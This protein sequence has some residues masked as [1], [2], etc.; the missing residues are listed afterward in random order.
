MNIEAEK[1]RNYLVVRIKDDLNF[2]T[3]IVELRQVIE[4]SLEHEKNFAISLTKNSFLSSMTIG[5]ILQC[6]GMIHE[7][8]GKMAFIHPN[9]GDSDLLETLSFTCIIETY[10]SEEEFFK[11]NM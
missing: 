3:N 10:R 8:G 4:D 11:V 2:D 9:E 7:R 1:F 6:Y 5:I